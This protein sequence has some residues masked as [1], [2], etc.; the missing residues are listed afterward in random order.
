MLPCNIVTFDF[1]LRCFV[2]R[3]PKC[4][5]IASGHNAR[6]SDVSGMLIVCIKIPTVV[7]WLPNRRK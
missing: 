6:D 4:S 7:V 1:L 2:P 3:L 5:L